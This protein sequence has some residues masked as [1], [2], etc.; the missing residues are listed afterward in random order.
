MQA[1]RYA[2][3]DICMIKYGYTTSSPLSLCSAN[4]HSSS[5]FPGWLAI[6]AFRL[7]VTSGL[8]AGQPSSSCV[9]STREAKGKSSGPNDHDLMSTGIRSIR[10]LLSLCAAWEP[11]A[12]LTACTMWEVQIA[13]A[14]FVSSAAYWRAR[15]L[16][17]LKDSHLVAT[18][19]VM[20]STSS[21]HTR[22]SHNIETRC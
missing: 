8:R 7:D 18:M 4:D 21:P 10:H 5:A 19:L 12:A 16:S 20:T 13:S 17:V 11:L 9:D 15:Y 6:S 2:Y 1:W 14:H 22:S 3:A